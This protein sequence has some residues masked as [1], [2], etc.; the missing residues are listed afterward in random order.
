MIDE[1]TTSLRVTDYATLNKA[2][3]DVDRRKGSS[4]ENPALQGIVQEFNDMELKFY[5]PVPLNVGCHVTVKLPEQY[6]VSTI[7]S[8]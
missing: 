3:L 7:N 5:F 8:V 6:N 1:G 2:M 4:P